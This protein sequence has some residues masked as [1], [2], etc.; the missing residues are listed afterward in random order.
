MSKDKLLYQKIIDYYI[1]QIDSGRIKPGDRIPT[2]FELA[3]IF[4]V[5]RITVTRAV[6][7]LE[8]MG[9]MYRVKRKG[10]FVK[11]YIDPSNLDMNNS[12]VKGTLL[13]KMRIISILLPFDERIGYEVLRGA[14]HECEKHK[15]Y[16]SF[17]NVEDN[18]D[19]E[20]SIIKDIVKNNVD[21]IIIYP[22]TCTGY[23]NLDV[24]SNIL[25]QKIPLVTID[26][27]I[28]GLNIPS[29]ACNNYKGIYDVVSHLIQLGHKKIAFV[30]SAIKETPTIL[31]RYKGYCNA[32]IDAG[33]ILNS[34]WIVND[35]LDLNETGVSTI[36]H[37]DVH[38]DAANRVVERLISLDDK[39]TAIVAVNDFTAKFIMEAALKKGISI[40]GE[41]SITG[42][43]NLWF[44]ENLEVPLTTVEQ[45]FYS[46]GERAVREL[47]NTSTSDEYSPK[48][49][50]LDTRIIVRKS[51]APPA[52]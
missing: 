20:R 51:T 24:L 48:R 8:N 27:H 30:C 36:D 7:E 44:A 25:I 52:G 13:Q 31:E 14:Q 34:K 37:P 22:S 41:L 28:E 49:I 4:Q 16:I 21:G 6:K 43:D 46:M 19:K 50:K 2:E 15:Y 5:S 47:L 9:L 32:M 33:I 40:P 12:N 42:F 26:R 1:E 17:H 45:P 18:T 10:T 35:F 39:P 38:L 3:D 23:K 29:V 11:Q